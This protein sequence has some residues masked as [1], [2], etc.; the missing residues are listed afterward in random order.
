MDSSARFLTYRNFRVSEGISHQR[1]N[2]LAMAKEAA[3]AQRILLLPEFRLS[4]KHNRGRAVR[5]K[6]G[7]YFD[8]D[9]LTV[10]GKPVQT[11]LTVPDSLNLTVAASCP[12][13]GRPETTVVK[14]IRGI[15]LLRTCLERIY[16]EF[17]QLSAN[18]PASRE[19]EAMAQRVVEKLPAGT[20]W[21]HARRGDLLHK[22][23]F[24]T[25]PE[26]IHSVI[27]QRFSDAKAVYLA[28]NELDLSVFQPLNRH[29]HV[30]TYLTFPELVDL[31]RLD[32]YRL[33]LVEQTIGRMCPWRISTFK[34]TGAYFHASLCHISGW[35]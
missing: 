17:T 30:A 33:F 2:L 13:P 5:T 27:Q 4:A 25:S 34:T 22:T 21:I 12:V 14:D 28:T 20:V 24:A 29:Y 3:I 19:L 11:A 1:S 35:Q 32:N 18:V 15:S 8:L 7:E 16:P 6:L 31:W 23:S 9:A 26:N 10:D